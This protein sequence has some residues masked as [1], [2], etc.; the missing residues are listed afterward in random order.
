MIKILKILA[1][2][3]PL[4]GLGAVFALPPVFAQGWGWGTQNQPKDRRPSGAYEDYGRS[5]SYRSEPD[6]SARSP[7]CRQLEDQLAGGWTR[8]SAEVQDQLPK[9]DADIEKASRDYR[10]AQ[11]DAER[12][13]CYDDMFIFGRSLRQTRKCLDLD[14]QVN[15]T[16]SNL[17]QLRS[18]RESMVRSTDRR[19]VQN[20]LLAELARND[21]GDAYSRE[22][23]SLNRPSFF[24]F[25]S[26]EDSDD[27]GNS[28]GYPLDAAGTYTTL[29]VRL[30]D[31][32]Y[33]PISY[34]TLPSR[35]PED[36]RK[37]QSQ[38]AAPSE[39]FYHRIPD[40][41]VEQAV[42]LDGKPYTA[43]PNAFRNRK[44]Y[45]RGCSC[46][47]NEYSRDE[48]A[49]SEEA[50]RQKSAATNVSE[51]SAS[52]GA[53]PKSDAAAA[54]APSGAESGAPLPATI[55]PDESDSSGG[56]VQDKT[57]AASQNPAPQA[58]KTTR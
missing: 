24:D 9:L 51:H 7:R 11:A 47:A 34:S 56:E 27:Q 22:Y 17:A 29:C 3:A 40:Q 20:D 43:L 53:P 42:S 19:A 32:F 2:S 23:R 45:I 37:C 14:G 35:F 15:S 31:G 33:F 39:L 50:L 13:D 25:W 4:A 52:H 57:A 10:R 12:A 8:N 18:Q 6:S 21:C 1:L 49:K 55:P 28:S 44:V 26:D 38:C 46:K 58:E 16:R 41:D 5:R 54:K 48:I 36:A 30:C